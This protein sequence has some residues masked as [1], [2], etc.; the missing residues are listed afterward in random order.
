[1]TLAC[2]DSVKRKNENGRVRPNVHEYE[3]LDISISDSSGDCE[4]VTYTI[5][6]KL[7]VYGNEYNDTTYCND[8]ECRRL[9]IESLII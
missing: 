5:K 2:L 1:M 4:E 9:F 6:I 7:D 3:Q 8:D